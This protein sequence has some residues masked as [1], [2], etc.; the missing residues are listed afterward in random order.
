MRALRRAACISIA[1]TCMS[2]SGQI[3]AACLD[4]G[5]Q[6]QILG[7]GGPGSSGGR[8]SSAYIVWIDGVG[9]ILIDAGSGTKDQF[10]AA[11]ASLED[12]E[13]IALSHFHPDHSAELPAILWPSGLNTRFVQ[14]PGTLSENRFSLDTVP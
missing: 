6:V 8:A 14:L 11:D 10:Y 9:R 7:S 4:S 3:W 1:A 13:L 5:M 12:I 2:F